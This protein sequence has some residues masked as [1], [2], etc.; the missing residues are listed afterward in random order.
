VNFLYDCDICGRF[1]RRDQAWRMCFFSSSVSSLYPSF[2]IRATS[3]LS[4][5]A[6]S[7]FMAESIALTTIGTD[8]FTFIESF[9]SDSRTPYATGDPDPVETYFSSIMFPSNKR[10]HGRSGVCRKDNSVFANYADCGSQ[11]KTPIL[12]GLRFSNLSSV[13]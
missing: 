13:R 11:F 4:P 3:K 6:E 1:E 5:L 2:V 7:L 10:S 12:G 9:H 8:S